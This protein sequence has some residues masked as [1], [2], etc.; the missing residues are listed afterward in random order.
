M[1]TTFKDGSEAEVSMFGYESVIGVS[2]L[3]GTKQSLNRIY[4]Q[5][6]GRGFVCPIEKAKKEFDQGGEFQRLCLRYVQMQLTHSP[7]RPD[8]ESSTR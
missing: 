5:I 1:T 4:M 2:G 8:A 3:M 6:A 7:R